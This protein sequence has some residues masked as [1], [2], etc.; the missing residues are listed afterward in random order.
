MKNKIQPIKSIS[1]CL[2]QQN[3]WTLQ[4]LQN[5]SKQTT[6]HDVQRKET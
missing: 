6:N 4:S 5:L 3:V 2:E 1:V